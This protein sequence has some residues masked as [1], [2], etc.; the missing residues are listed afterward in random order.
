MKALYAEAP[1][2][3]VLRTDYPIPALK[4]KGVRVKVK[5]SGVAPRLQ[6]LLAGKTKRCSLARISN[7]SLVGEIFTP[8]LAFPFVPGGG[9][10]GIVD[11]IG[12]EVVSDLKKGE[13]VICSYHY[14]TTSLLSLTKYY[15]L[16]L[17]T[18]NPKAR[19]L[20][21][22]CKDSAIGELSKVVNS[23]HNGGTGALQSMQ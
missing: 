4:A 20:M 7:S 5:L 11:E 21:A 15:Y 16:S 22:F 2:Q 12:P 10:I 18:S 14:G 1:K 13:L 8:L 9:P 23:K 17:S 19:C 6:A 3:T